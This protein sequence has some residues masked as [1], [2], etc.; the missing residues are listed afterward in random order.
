M[1]PSVKLESSKTQVDEDKLKNLV[2]DYLNAI[3]RDDARQLAEISEVIKGCSSEQKVQFSFELLQRRSKVRPE[4]LDFD[5]TPREYAILLAKIESFYGYGW[6]P[7]HL[8]SIILEVLRKEREQ[9]ADVVLE[10]V[11][12][13]KKALISWLSQILPLLPDTIRSLSKNEFLTE[14]MKD[15]AENFPLELALKLGN[16]GA[17][18]LDFLPDDFWIETLKRAI[19][20]LS[21]RS[22]TLQ[23]LGIARIHISEEK[24][25][26]FLLE[27]LDI[28]WKHDFADY[29]QCWFA[30]EFLETFASFV[31]QDY[32]K[33]PLFQ[34]LLWL[35]EFY[36]EKSENR[37][38]SGIKTC[39]RLAKAFVAD[40]VCEIQA[41]EMFKI[42]LFLRSKWP[43]DLEGEDLSRWAL[44]SWTNS[45]LATFPKSPNSL[46]LIYT[47]LLDLRRQ[48]GGLDLEVIV[49]K[50]AL[51]RSNFH[52]TIRCLKLLEAWFILAGKTGI[53]N[54]QDLLPDLIGMAKVDGK[55]TWTLSAHTVNLAEKTL[56]QWVSKLGIQY[57]ERR[58]EYP[59]IL[60]KVGYESLENW[61]ETAVTQIESVF[62]SFVD[63]CI[64][65]ARL[66]S[67][68]GLLGV[69]GVQR[70]L[71]FIV[72][73]WETEKYSSDFYEEETLEIW[74]QDQI[75]ID[76]ITIHAGDN[77]KSL[78]R[79]TKGLAKVADSPQEFEAEIA[80]II[81]ELS[82]LEELSVEQ[83]RSKVT[84]ILGSSGLMLYPEFLKST[85]R[86]LVEREDF[87][88]NTKLQNLGL[89]ITLELLDRAE[90]FKLPKSDRDRLKQ[91]KAIIKPS[92][93]KEKKLIAV[94]VVTGHPN[95]LLRA[96][97]LVPGV[98]SCLDPFHGP[99]SKGVGGNVV[100]PGIKIGATY[101]FEHPDVIKL[102]EK[103][104]DSVRLHFDPVREVLHVR[105]EYDGSSEYIIPL[106]GKCRSRTI[107]RL[108]K[109][110]SS[111][112]PALLR[113]ESIQNLAEELRNPVSRIW[114][115]L[116]RTLIEK[117]KAEPAKPGDTHFPRP[118]VDWEF[119]VWFEPTRQHFAGPYVWQDTP[120]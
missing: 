91:I 77:L 43:E 90:E 64:Y 33:K 8:G 58:A 24:W 45:S 52:T 69:A 106:K 67:R 16:L 18:E 22:E 85:L 55:C 112:R 12:L 34:Q 82:N 39:K 62:G 116:E 19:F 9:I 73:G 36:S 107:L 44:S 61:E 60:E 2:D 28:L 59:A 53:K 76:V 99:N 7:D 65:S 54:P 50:D 113:D 114:E 35:C 5:L 20:E 104:S 13:D 25:E 29:S 71:E 80:N 15:L 96:G 79:L 105:G 68:G 42:L 74:R 118:K 100:E 51:E 83:V 11:D 75:R 119:G 94:S 21:D 49:E 40:G 98:Y 4:H 95:L 87:L 26:K 10:L 89:A 97:A 3:T 47:T 27:S 115:D 1:V 93:S 81:K 32:S 41:S 30:I 92:G 31:F 46:R 109:N 120:L 38:C 37:E 6:G 78:R 72:Q 117:L 66:H 23:L 110:L 56:R 108:G 103:S 86:H 57:L 111:G 88:S 101:V 14:L 17:N 102:L 48:S 70:L 63:F 84:N